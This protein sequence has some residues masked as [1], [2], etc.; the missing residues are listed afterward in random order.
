MIMKKKIIS[1]K[2]KRIERKMFDKYQNFMINSLD[3]V[4]QLKHKNCSVN[5]YYIHL[6]AL[7]NKCFSIT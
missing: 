2:I 4:R 1:I 3:L 7:M 5:K 6:T